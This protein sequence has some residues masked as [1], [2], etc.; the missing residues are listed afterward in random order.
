M[1]SRL[2]RVLVVLSGRRF[3]ALGG[4]SVVHVTPD[5]LVSPLASGVDTLVVGYEGS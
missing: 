4:E 5:G 1:G 2:L 3:A